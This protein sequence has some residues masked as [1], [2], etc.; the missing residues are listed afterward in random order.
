[1][2]PGCVVLP[3]FDVLGDA[4]IPWAQEGLDEQAKSVAT[5]HPVAGVGLEPNVEV[6]LVTRTVSVNP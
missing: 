4:W 6:A 5:G 2:I 1:M 3:H